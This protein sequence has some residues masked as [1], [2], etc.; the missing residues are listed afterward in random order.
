MPLQWV[1]VYI[2]CKISLCY[3]LF[4][5]LPTGNLMDVAVPFSAVR[6]D[7]VVVAYPPL[8]DAAVPDGVMILQILLDQFTL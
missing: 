1:F 2:S 6:G 7:A 8:R 3:I 4:G 5:C